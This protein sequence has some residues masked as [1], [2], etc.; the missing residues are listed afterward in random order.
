MLSK[1]TKTNNTFFLKFILSHLFHLTLVLSLFISTA[2]SSSLTNETTNRKG[3][4]NTTYGLQ[5][6]YDSLYWQEF[7]NPTV[8]DS[9]ILY[10]FTDSIENPT[11]TFVLYPPSSEEMPTNEGQTENYKTGIFTAITTDTPFNTKSYYT[12]HKQK[13]YKISYTNIKAAD[14]SKG[15][16]LM[17]YLTLF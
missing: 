8:M 13:T 10:L 2:C 15:D 16:E 1:K 6:S 7:S 4:Y 9:A 5:L 12:T 17:N 14:F 3:F 11:E